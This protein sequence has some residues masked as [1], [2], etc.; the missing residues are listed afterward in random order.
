MFIP[1]SR[2]KYSLKLNYLAKV[3]LTPEIQPF[4]MTE[5]NLCISFLGVDTFIHVSGLINGV[6]NPIIKKVMCIRIHCNCPLTDMENEPCKPCAARVN[7][8]GSGKFLVW[9]YAFFVAD[10][11]PA[12][13]KLPILGKKDPS[14]VK[15]PKVGKVTQPVWGSPTWER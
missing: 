5:S 4:Q 2:W 12:W 6:H 3:L 8:L 14:W 9:T 7:F 11:Y 10:G 13:V 15:L 1:P